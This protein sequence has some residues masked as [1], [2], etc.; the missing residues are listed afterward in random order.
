VRKIFSEEIHWIT[1]MINGGDRW[2]IWIDDHQIEEACKIREISQRLERVKSAREA[3]RGDQAKGG[4]S[5][6]HKFV[7][8]PHRSG[9]AIAVPK[10]S[11]A[12]RYYI[13][14]ILTDAYTI[15]SDLARVIYEVARLIYTSLIRWIPTNISFPALVLEVDLRLIERCM[16]QIVSMMLYP[17]PCGWANAQPI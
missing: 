4:I 2:C 8:A 13:P 10:V 14:C 1:R 7:F 15:V 16:E 17:S 6:P 11:S 3:S 9:S 12:R 5:T